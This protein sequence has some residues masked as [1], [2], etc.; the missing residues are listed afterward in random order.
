MKKKFSCPTCGN[1]ELT[2][3]YITTHTGK[4][5]SLHLSSQA[6]IRKSSGEVCCVACKET[7]S[8]AEFQKDKVSA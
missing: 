4:N 5:L 3:M 8:L 2:N 7:W 1:G 6:A